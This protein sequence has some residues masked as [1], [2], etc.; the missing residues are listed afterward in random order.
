MELTADEADLLNTLTAEEIIA[1]NAPAIPP[2]KAELI[3]GHH[4]SEGKQIAPRGTGRR[5]Y[6]T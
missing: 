6:R 1:M 4:W 2:R 3:A 5:G